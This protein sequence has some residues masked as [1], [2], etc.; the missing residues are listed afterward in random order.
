[1]RAPASPKLFAAALALASLV[2]VSG[3]QTG[4]ENTVE[5]AL[6]L[7]VTPLG[8][9]LD[10][11]IW[12]TISHFDIAS[13]DG[14]PPESKSRARVA[15]G[16]H[17]IVVHATSG[18]SGRANSTTVTV[19]LRSGHTYMLR[20]TTAGGLVYVIVL[21]NDLGMVVARSDTPGEG[22]AALL[23]GPPPPAPKPD[24]VETNVDGS[25]KTR[26]VSTTDGKGHVIKYTVYD[27]A[28]RTLSTQLSF[29]APDGRLV[30]R[31]DRGADDKLEKVTVYF[32]TFSK[33]LDGNG[34]LLETSGPAAP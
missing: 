12:G 31:D 6:I 30:R 19:T 28:G 1:M 7:G 33:V 21:D 10:P 29:Y 32:D 13:V 17:T 26:G 11:I 34:N 5:P 24:V 25:L 27:G 18:W 20:P 22:S 16:P 3:C 4:A 14:V 8:L 15:P 2:L 9:R 23:D